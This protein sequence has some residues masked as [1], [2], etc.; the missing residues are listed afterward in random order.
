[1][2]VDTSSMGKIT[3]AVEGAV[4]DIA[5]IGMGCRFP[6]A[7]SPGQFWQNQLAQR[8][9][10]TTVP[11]DRWDWRRFHDDDPER[12]GKLY[13]NRGGY[14]NDIDRFDADFFGIAPAESRYLDPQQRLLLEVAWETLENAQIQ[15]A[16]VRSTDL[17]VFI[18]IS[19]LDYATMTAQ[20]TPLDKISPYCATGSA[21]STAAGRLAYFLGT[22]GPAMS[23]DTACS[24]SLVALH[25]AIRS[26]R[27]G[28]SSQAL[29]A[30]VNVLLAIEP[31]MNFARAHM[32]SADGKCKTFSEQADG[33]VRGEGCGAVL[34]KPL[35][36]AEVAGDRIFAVIRGSAVNQDGA[37]AGLT[38]PYG[39]AQSAVIRK[40]LEDADA[41]PDDIGY[42]E[43]HG[44]GT[45]LG[46]PIELKA[47]TAV[48]R[49]DSRHAPLPVGSVKTQIGHLEPAAGMASLIR[50][51]LSL[52]SKTLPAHLWAEEPTTKV[53]WDMA[54]LRVMGAPE[55]WDTS[56]P[57]VAGV[58]GFGFSGTNAHVVLQEY[59]ATAQSRAVSD[60]LSDA[61]E[62]ASALFCLSAKDSVALVELGCRYLDVV[63]QNQALDIRQLAFA[64]VARRA[65]FP[66]RAWW[67]VADR[68]ELIAGLET[69][70][71]AD[72]ETLDTAGINYS[73]TRSVNDPVIA[74]M[75]SGQGSQWAGMGQSL[76]QHNRVFRAN[77]ARCD[78]VFQQERRGQS[79]AAMVFG[80]G[81][82]DSL[83][84]TANTQPALYAF[85][86]SLAACLTSAG[87]RPAIVLGHS[88]GEFVAA[89]VA[90]VFT[91]EDGMRLV[92][93]RGSAMQAL[94]VGGGMLAV[95]DTEDSLRQRIDDEGFEL[96]I[97][98][99]NAPSQVVVSGSQ[100]QLD[101][102]ANRLTNAG[103]TTRALKVSHAFHSRLMQPMLEPFREACEAVDFRPPECELISN[104]T[105]QAVGAEVATTQYWMEHVRAPVQFCQSVR[106]LATAYCDL[107]LEV[108]PQATL[109][110]SAKLCLAEDMSDEEMPAIYPCSRRGQDSVEAFRLTLG[111][112][113]GRGVV[114]DWSAEI[115]QWRDTVP[116]RTDLTL[117][118]YPFQRQSFWFS[119][120]MPRE[121]WESALRDPTASVGTFCDGLLGRT[122][123]LAVGIDDCS[124]YQA[125]MTPNTP[126]F[127]DDHRVFSEIVFPAAG[128]LDMLVGAVRQHPKASAAGALI[129][130]DIVIRRPIILGKHP[131]TLQTVRKTDT[132]TIFVLDGNSEQWQP[133][134]GA[135]FDFADRAVESLATAVPSAAD[136]DVSAFYGAMREHGLQ[137]GSAFRTV[138]AISVD[139]S[140]ETARVFAELS[141][142]SVALDSYRGLID[143]T[144]LDGAF[145]TAAALL[146]DGEEA[147]LHPDR[148][149]LPVAIDEV[150]VPL[151]CEAI[152]STAQT[153]LTLV[154]QRPAF[155]RVDLKL[156]YAGE[157]TV[158]SVTGLRLFSANRES[159]LAGQ[160]EEVAKDD[161]SFELVW[162]TTAPAL[163]D[164]HEGGRWLLVH[165]DWG[166]AN[167]L[168]AQLHERGLDID[169][170]S[171]GSTERLTP[172]GFDVE[173]DEAL[174]ASAQV[175]GI[176]VMPPAQGAGDLA[177]E[178]LDPGYRFLR[179]INALPS[180]RFNR[181]VVLRSSQ[182]SDAQSQLSDT[183][184]EAFAAMSSVV[185]KECG[186]LFAQIEFSST[187]TVFD[188]MAKELAGPLPD[189]RLRLRDTD[190]QA[191]RL[192]SKA[193]QITPTDLRLLDKGSDYRLML[194]DYG[195][196]DQLVLDPVSIASPSGAEVSVRIEA[197][198]LNFK[199]LL[200]ALGGLAEYLESVGYAHPSKVPLGFEAAGVVTA[201][202]DSVT[203]LVPGQK[204]VV[205]QTGCMASAVTVSRNCVAALPVGLSF[206][207]GAALPTVFMTAL[208]A[209]EQLA[210]LGAGDS[211]LIHAAAGGV[212]QAALQVARARGAKIFATASPSKW[213]WLRSQG[214]DHVYSSRDTAFARAIIADTDG[215]GVSVVLNALNG[216]FIEAGLDALAEGGRFI[217]IGKVGVWTAE[218]MRER[219]PDVSYH[220]FDLADVT[221][222]QPEVFLKLQRALWSRFE[223]GEFV[224]LPTEVFD[225]QEAESAMRHMSQARHIGKVALRFPRHR[226][227]SPVSSDRSYL[228]TG[229][230][231]GIGIALVEWLVGL[232]AENLLL[233]SR[234]AS[235]DLQSLLEKLQV[236]RINIRWLA[237]DIANAAH[238]DRCVEVAQSMAP[239]AG[240]FHAA[241]ATTDGLFADM[242][243]GA[244]RDVFAGKAEGG[245]HLHR[246]TETIHQL[247]H[248]IVFSSVS[249]VY[250]TPGQSNYAAANAAL[251]R[252]VEIRW[253]SGLPALG[254]NWG[255]WAG[256]GMAAGME[257]TFARL[258]VR[259]LQPSRALGVLKRAMLEPP[260]RARLLVTE[261][262]WD[263][264]TKINDDSL[265]ELLNEGASSTTAG[266]D[267]TVRGEL[268]EELVGLAT[269][270][271]RRALQQYLQR[272]LANTLGL[273]GDQLLDASASFFDLG[274]D[275]LM[276]MELKGRLEQALDMR[277]QPTVLIEAGNL[278]ELTETLLALLT[279]ELTELAVETLPQTDACVADEESLEGL[280][281]DELEALLAASLDD[282]DKVL[283]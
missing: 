238:V 60:T 260:R 112:C 81:N 217:E 110:A 51:V 167:D 243:W 50:V 258:G 190:R 252:L 229:A 88:I 115:L 225:V 173:L 79:L 4:T 14:L 111:A 165:W 41:A 184:A 77:F 223:S 49:T 170:F 128:Y 135:R 75:F 219:R 178:T 231:G 12:P 188:L 102:L 119:E 86:A 246:A 228:V 43:A 166:G 185:A 27:A 255:P 8:D 68:D 187:P 117:P 202:G 141:R 54:G 162:H 57:R 11:R 171:L 48:F 91:L 210:E 158:I 58:S 80:E 92:C 153:E 249:S 127:L 177:V 186:W 35:A 179:A 262:Q 105:G 266:V 236:E 19:A 269:P 87:L 151:A 276:G 97:A 147:G 241:G 200:V 122:L 160:D 3:A 15:P 256:A 89:H 248:F 198:A 148:V 34:L 114:P 199:D 74:F 237:G 176:L 37:S 155:S 218:Q 78:A 192:T 205:T 94:P 17:G 208:Y 230:S 52:Q 281:E 9:C 224:A 216:D 191:L 66:S 264:F 270:Q 232:G 63:R 31:S 242:N 161:A 273:P 38:A 120:R 1:M 203:D 20:Q 130:R 45:P 168:Q 137:Y 40:A 96:D 182:T 196:F 253:A 275:S 271:R 174:G 197:A 85:E 67:C 32:L 61:G 42:L 113:Y 227:G 263:T 214:V 251:D 209:L 83:M 211:V 21:L 107:L 71:Q 33:Y 247:E 164:Q 277:L 16:A 150:S 138:S 221:S 90:G 106:A 22:H 73:R 7:D 139:E 143:P 134:A 98:A 109:S 55:P 84:L 189:R 70:A 279:A 103:V 121:R 125:V 142:R 212:G 172:E 101:A 133:V 116:A 259:P 220:L 62:S 272:Q 24:S 207:E 46:D 28:E 234:K 99:V 47:L 76:Y 23:I 126:E 59:L 235:E 245:W 194:K 254:I 233:T 26:L 30:G 163:A 39:P 82:D 204:V 280:S 257:D 69:L 132:V 152:P 226:S 183:A 157:T 274:L 131:V 180:S 265:F 193:S 145:Q 140:G 222:Q 136:R 104:V 239:L 118:N 93:K 215:A 56:G 18:G 36:E 201:V 124:I 5:I 169:L 64:T 213:S 65:D 175:A 95:F 261:T 267:D 123:P 2:G 53:D 282:L 154:E 268:R 195:G 129:L 146:I 144:L 72:A 181:L 108:G 156:R 6:G 44:T 10:V 240:V 250:S 149:F 25:T 206:A 283:S 29:V 159:L 244:L 278:E 13:F 100:F